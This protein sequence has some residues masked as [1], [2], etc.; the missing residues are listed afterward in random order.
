MQGIIRL[1]GGY[2]R[3]NNGGRGREMPKFNRVSSTGYK[4][5]KNR[6]FLS[7]AVKLYKTTYRDH[8]LIFNVYSHICPPQ[9]QRTLMLG[10]H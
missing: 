6:T 8:S 2:C 10:K 7:R 1:Y 5:S 3:F 4:Y 9:P